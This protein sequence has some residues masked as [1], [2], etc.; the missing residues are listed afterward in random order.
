VKP[1]VSIL[2]PAYNAERWITQTV[3]SA[4][5]QSWDRKEVI[6]VDDGSRDATFQTAK[7]LESTLVKVVRQENGG[8]CAARNKAM[9][10]AQGDYIQFLDADDLLAPAKIALQLNRHA[11]AGVDPGVL[12]TSSWGRFFFHPELAAFQPDALWTD[13]DPVDWLITKF[14]QGVWMNPSAWLVS[15][16]L[17]EQAGP[18]DPS[19]S[20]SGD[21]DGEYMCRLV[22]KSSRV[23]FSR[24]AQAFYRVGNT[25]GL[26]WR[27]SDKALETFLMATRLCLQ[28]LRSLEDSDRTR[29]ACLAL[30]QMRL[31]YFHPMKPELVET[32]NS[33]AATFGG[34]VTPPQPTT[35]FRLASCVVGFETAM[36]LKATVWTA[37]MI[38]KKNLERAVYALSGRFS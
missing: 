30:L 11:K 36:K 15:R 5:D 37:E 34:S 21:D 6:V 4:L 10:L 8:A 18:W 25:G 3:S 1:L 29:A 23:E 24:E 7:R 22:A 35:I 16:H 38:W 33:L 26:S 17:T 19:L 31:R 12:L 32:V 9:E 27:K 13:L 14:E 2:I 20:F 28:H